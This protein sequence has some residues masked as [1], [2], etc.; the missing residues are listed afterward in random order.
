MVTLDTTTKWVVMLIV[1]GGVG[2]IGGIAAA[3]LEAKADATTAPPLTGHGK[4]KAFTC[5][6]VG[7]V[8]AVAVIYFFV[9]IKEVFPP[10]GGK[11]EAFYELIK[12]VP[13][14]LIVGSAG[15]YFLQSF[16]KQIE[17]RLATQAGN[18][19]VTKSE[20][21]VEA[22]QALS[23]QADTTLDNTKA[24]FQVLLQDQVP[25]LNPGAAEELAGKLVDEAKKATTDAIQ[26]Q[27]DTIERLAEGLQ[28]RIDRAPIS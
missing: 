11:P 3:L 18:Q 1:A 19:A 26:P 27:V 22:A 2:M 24:N 16:Q 14:S 25:A 23:Q 20:N 9:P 4:L 8:A 7:G 21:V 10:E 28:P 6:F 15:T 5:I 12:L 17:G 13:L